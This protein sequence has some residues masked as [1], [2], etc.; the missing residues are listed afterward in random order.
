MDQIA[1]KWAP[2]PR[3][4]LCNITVTRGKG[5][6]MVLRGETMFR[7]AREE[8]VAWARE[9]GRPF[10][11]SISILPDT[12]A[13]PKYLGLVM[14]SV[15]NIR[16]YPAHESEMVSQAVL[17]TP[18][19]LMKK[20]RDW[21]FIQTP[22][23]YLGW[24]EESSVIL[25]DPEERASWQRSDR[26]VYLAN[27]GWIYGSTDRKT[28]TGDIV[29]GAIVTRKN[30]ARNGWVEI[31]LPDGRKGFIEEAQVMDFRKWRSQSRGTP[32]EMI[33]TALSLMGVPYLWGG[34][35]P[36]AA[37]CSGFIQSVFFRNGIVLPRDA[38]QQC[39]VGK[40]VDVSQGID[41]L[42]AGDLLF[43][44]TRIND[45]LRITHVALFLGDTGFI[46]ESGMVMTA[47]LDPSRSNYDKYRRESL[48]VARRIA[49]ACEKSG[50]VTISE[51]PWY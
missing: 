50:I 14:Q 17:G 4:G 34:T 43:F 47:S 33:N 7:G 15:I 6:S 27:T 8:A 31:A 28:V 39:Q 45:T 10:T 19:R 26:L 25:M 23:Q 42:Q 29:A 24:T 48:I 51:H 2:D 37:D 13:N 22:D 44:G 21:L 3:N 38:S 1:G 5:K 9:S 11:D 20:Y 40:G 32:E 16:K 41:S 36:K 49:G 18:V 35:S 12:L 46:H 30:S